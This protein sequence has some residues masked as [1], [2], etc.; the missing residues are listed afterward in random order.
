MSKL[1]KASKPVVPVRVLGLSKN[2][3]LQFVKD[4]YQS[5]FEHICGSM[6]GSDTFYCS[7][8]GKME[9]MREHI[10]AIIY[11]DGVVGADVIA[12]MALFTRHK[13]GA[14]R[15]YCGAPG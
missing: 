4:S 15:A 12:K 5:L 14:N 6:Y 2:G 3:N 9:S 10:K 8:K 1:N 7:A 11:A 13:L